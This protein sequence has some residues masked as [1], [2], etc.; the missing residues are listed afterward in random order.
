MLF[1]R[2]HQSSSQSSQASLSQ[3]QFSPRPFSVQEPNHLLTQDV[4]NEAFDQNK[5]EAFGL[6]L[7]EKYGTIIPDEQERLAVLQGKMNSFWAQRIGPA[8]VQPNIIQ[9]KGTTIGDLPESLVEQQSNKTGLPNALKA[10]VEKLS[11]YSLEHVRVH[12][13]SPKPAQLQAL[14]YTQGTEVYVAPTQEKHLPHEM[15]HVV[16]QAQGRVKPTMHLQDGVAVNDDE[17]LEHEADVMGAKA[18]TMRDAVPISLATTL[19]KTGGREIIQ[20]VGE[21]K[22]DFKLAETADSKACSE[23]E[24]LFK[25]ALVELRILRQARKAD[26][27]KSVTSGSKPTR[28][29]SEAYGGGLKNLKNIELLKETKQFTSPVPHLS[30]EGNK[31]FYQAPKEG[32]GTELP[33][34]VL[35]A[36]L[37][38]RTF[39]PLAERPDKANRDVLISGETDKHYV[40]DD[41][42]VPTRRYAYVEKNYWQFMEFMARN[43]LEGRYQNFFRA[44]N[45]GVERPNVRGVRKN[46]SM[47]IRSK[48]GKADKPLTDEQL[49]VLH[50]WKGS[51]LQQR[52]LSLTSTP[53]KGETIGNAGENFRTQIGVRLTIDL[54]RIPKEPDSPI[55]I[56]HYAYSGVKDQ[57]GPVAKA[58]KEYSYIDSVIKNRELF[59]EFVKPEWIVNIEYHNAGGEQNFP[60][61]DK[62]TADAMMDVARAGTGYQKFA[63][64][65]AAQIAGGSLS[66]LDKNDPDYK[67]GIEFANEYDRGYE[68]GMGKTEVKP[69]TGSSNI[70]PLAQIGEFDPKKQ[71]D[72]FAIGRIHG[73]VRRAKPTT[74]VEIWS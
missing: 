30:L 18:S 63:D 32:E 49:A 4:E 3:S 69:L 61:L 26:I 34:P 15:W 54:A 40:Y 51:G 17:G 42:N 62:E 25:E 73:R 20:R 74:L 31:V 22:Q 24:R 48:K 27:F 60:R 13:N 23:G 68:Q 59:L 71:K 35:V 29:Y 58:E 70:D 11:G 9:A 41:R 37:T 16:Q 64:G 50:Q 65:F 36:T 56:N 8:K 53:R 10:G 67:S 2:V 57:K 19:P 66:D 44:A 5:F 47:M 12:Y 39:Q 72:V 21:E 14:A 43:K 6:Q 33:E 52:G 1:Q 55:L 46:E 45:F 7:K 38:T 28:G